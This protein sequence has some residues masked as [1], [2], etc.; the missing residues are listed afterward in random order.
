[1]INIDTGLSAEALLPR[2]EQFFNL[3]ADKIRLLDSEW[4]ARQGS[5][6]FTVDGK[7]TTRGWTEWTQGFQ[8]GCALL[9]FDAEGDE[10]FLDLG[11]QRTVDLLRAL[12][13]EGVVLIVATHDP[14]HFAEVADHSLRLNGGHLVVDESVYHDLPETVTPINR[15]A[16][17]TV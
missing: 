3:A 16:R 6:V 17:A 2:L 13:Q 7:Y 1:M 9:Q 11:R 14:M 5:P 12:K 4:D 10:G 15:R 8:F